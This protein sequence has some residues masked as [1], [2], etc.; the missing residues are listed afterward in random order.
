MATEATRPSPIAADT[1]ERIA[2][3]GTSERV[4]GPALA[5]A[6][7][8]HTGAFG[9][10]ATRPF[11]IRAFVESVRSLAMDRARATI[12][13]D[14]EPAP[15]PPPPPEPEPVVQPEPVETP[16]PAAKEPPP[17]SPMK[18]APAAAPAEA[19]KLLTAEPDPNEP[20]DLTDQGFVSGPG[21]RYAGGLTSRTGTSKTAVPTIQTR[22]AGVV[23]GTG[24]AENVGAG[25]PDKSRPA[26]PASGGEWSDCG[27]PP[28]ADAE[29]INL[30]K[31]T[32]V[33]IVDPAGRPT[34]ARAVTDTGYGF[35]K[36]AERCAMRKVYDPA[37]D[38]LG[39]PISGAT[40]PFTVRFSR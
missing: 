3:V 13:I 22:P 20:L 36:R 26:K 23:G 2:R 31:V 30:G 24:K 5:L 33:V 28:E 37:L 8:F 14:E 17:P 29:Q 10:G 38:K 4:L 1:F 7:L 11:E 6:L 27:F 9:Y 21:D 25:L 19:G 18:E 40:V 32:L 39:R 16:E 35:G 15:P 12:D 34:S